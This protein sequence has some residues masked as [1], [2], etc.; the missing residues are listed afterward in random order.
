MTQGEI[1]KLKK[2]QENLE[3]EGIRDFNNKSNPPKIIEEGL[4]KYEASRKLLHRI[5][6]LQDN[7]NVKTE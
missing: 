6:D 5:G 3:A 1:D 2:V 4:K 7:F